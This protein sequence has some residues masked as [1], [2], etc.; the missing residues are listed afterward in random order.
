MN[1]AFMEFG[2]SRYV[3]SIWENST[4]AERPVNDSRGFQPTVLETGKHDASRQRPLRLQRVRCERSLR[5]A[6]LRGCH[7]PWVETHGY[8]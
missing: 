8:W 5:D 6:L 3:R 7:F 2:K 1:V 4:I